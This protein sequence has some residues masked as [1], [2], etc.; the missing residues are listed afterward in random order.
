MNDLTFKPAG[1]AIAALVAGLAIPADVQAEAAMKKD[2]G[3]ELAAA[4]SKFAP[5]EPFAESPAK[6]QGDLFE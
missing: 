4:V 5:A 1:A 3:A 2:H 6:T